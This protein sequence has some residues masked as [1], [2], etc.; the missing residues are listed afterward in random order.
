VAAANAAAALHSEANLATEVLDRL[1]VACV[2][3]AWG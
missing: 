1:M 2:A 3:E